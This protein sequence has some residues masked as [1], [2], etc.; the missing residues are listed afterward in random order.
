MATMTYQ[1][2]V[3]S[4]CSDMTA[5]DA[6]SYPVAVLFIGEVG[7]TRLGVVSAINPI[8][9]KDVLQDVDELTSVLLERLPEVAHDQ[10]KELAGLHQESTIEDLIRYTHDALRNTLHVSEV[11]QVAREPVDSHEDMQARAFA[12]ASAELLKHARRHYAQPVEAPESMIGKLPERSL[13]V[14]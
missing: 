8:M 11:S 4:I 3:L 6:P 5:P 14:A 13:A 10:L 9:V 12:L 2:A 1:T 7:R